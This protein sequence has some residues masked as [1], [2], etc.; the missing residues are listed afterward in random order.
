MEQKDCIM[1]GEKM[2][3]QDNRGW[4]LIEPKY[5]MNELGIGFWVCP[6]CIYK[7]QAVQD[8]Q[9]NEI[10]TNYLLQEKIRKMKVMLQ[11]IIND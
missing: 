6:N 3:E 4:E 11:D 7:F 5:G 2:S 8:I 1:C 10:N 9:Q